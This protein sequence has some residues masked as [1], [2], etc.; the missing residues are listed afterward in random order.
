VKLITAIIKPFK[1]DDAKDALKAAGV[2][3]LTVTQV[4]GFGRQAGH[5]EVYRGAEYEVDFLPKIK[6]ELLCRDDDAAELVA[7]IA[8]ACRTGSIGDGKIWTTEVG[9][10]V[11]V[12]TGEVGEEAL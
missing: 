7:L 10:V 5:T 4:S 3:G 8:D 12:R 11:R 2:Q 9:S 6:I 1:V